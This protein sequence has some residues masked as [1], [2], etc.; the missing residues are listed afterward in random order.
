[1]E[2]A[3]QVGSVAGGSRNAP[4]GANDARMVVTDRGSR[5]PLGRER[6][7]CRSAMR[8]GRFEKS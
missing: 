7:G 5:H 1:M 6:A 2:T 4:V 3:P 8:C